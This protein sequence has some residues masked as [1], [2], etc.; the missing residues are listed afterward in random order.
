MLNDLKK[1][2]VYVCIHCWHLKWHT[3]KAEKKWDRDN[4]VPDCLC[5][6]G[7]VLWI[8]VSSDLVLFVVTKVREIKKNIRRQ[9]RFLHQLDIEGWQHLEIVDHDM[10]Q[11]REEFTHS[12]SH[13]EQAM[14]ELL[15]KLKVGFDKLELKVEKMENIAILGSST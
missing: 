10:S 7:I 9:N 3:T 1:N 8:H 5:L 11:L 6:N 12:I 13:T 15:D 2:H 14:T 4:L